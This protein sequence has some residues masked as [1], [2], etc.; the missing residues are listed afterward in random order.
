VDLDDDATELMPRSGRRTTPQHVARLVLA[1]ILILLCAW[2]LGGFL[3]ALG[4]ALILAIATWPL[5]DRFLL[6]LKEPQRRFLAPFLFTLLIALVFVAPLFF[7]AVAAGRDVNHLI[8]W[9]MEAEHNGVAAP[10]WLADV[11]LIGDQIQEWWTMHLAEPGAVTELMGYADKASLAHLTQV[12]GIL[13]A[14]R[15]MFFFFTVL[16]LFFLFRDGVML[17]RRFR[18]L[19]NRV[20]GRRGGHLVD[21]MVS[22]IRSTADG[23]VLVG[24]GEGALLAVAYVI[25]GVP[26]PALLGALTGLLAMIPFG[27]PVVFGLAS[28][29]LL[30]NGSLA[31]AIGVF[32]FG[33]LVLFVADHF[34]RPVLI[35]GAAKLPFLWVLLGIFGGLATFGVLGLFL[36]PALMAALVSLWREWTEPRRPRAN[37]PLI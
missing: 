28:V 22:A 29:L 18:T 3:A 1:G 11:P 26:H 25:A 37:V 20:L 7:A 21:L 17:G 14:R 13:I 32:V 24:L 9:A 10:G 15:L 5:Y 6:L 34:I 8:A 33:M 27:A 30:V 4:W 12:I 19:C 16:T 35:G 36:G 31:P 23:L 2:V